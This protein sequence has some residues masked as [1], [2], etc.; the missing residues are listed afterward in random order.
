MYLSESGSMSYTVA[1]YLEEK[2]CLDKKLSF[3]LFHNRKAY[4]VRSN[5]F[6]IISNCFASAIQFYPGKNTLILLTNSAIK[7]MALSSLW[8][9][10]VF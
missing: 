4:R 1:Q 6:M 2:K 7:M 8:P 9:F 3:A 5:Y 10:S